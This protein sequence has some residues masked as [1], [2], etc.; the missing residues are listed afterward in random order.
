MKVVG[1]DLYMRRGDTESIGVTVSGY[2][3]QDGDQIDFTVRRNAFSEVAIHKTV[4]DFSE[5]SAVIP[6]N[7]EDTENLQFGP[8]VYDIQLTYGGIVKTI[9]PDDPSKPLPIFNIGKEVT[10]D[11]N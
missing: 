5:N 11:G 10:Y 6:I 8:Y 4:T 3:L 7:P 9:V 1:F 2:T